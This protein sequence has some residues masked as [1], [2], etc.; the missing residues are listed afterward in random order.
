MHIDFICLT[1]MISFFKHQSKKWL[2]PSS[3]NLIIE[4]WKKNVPIHFF[5][6]K[7][8]I[9]AH[10]QNNALSCPMGW[11]NWIEVMI[12]CSLGESCDSW[13]KRAR[14]ISCNQKSR[15]W[16]FQFFQGG[17][18]PYSTAFVLLQNG[19]LDKTLRLEFGIFNLIFLTM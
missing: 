10:T 2:V 3:Y 15:E 14:S 5:P 4:L 19:I 17:P 9:Y 13:W 18:A 8:P 6:C 11:Q 7:I 1:F 12:D 16:K